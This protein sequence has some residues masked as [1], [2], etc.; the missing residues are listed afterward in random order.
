MHA[1]KFHFTSIGSGETFADF[2]G[3]GF[4][5]AIG[6]E[7]A[8]A[9]AGANFEVEAIDGDHVLISLAKAVTRRA[10]LEATADMDPVSRR[11]Q[12]R[13]SA[14]CGRQWVRLSK[15]D[16]QR[17]DHF[18]PDLGHLDILVEAAY[19]HLE[20]LPKNRQIASS[21]CKALWTF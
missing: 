13:S 21:C 3:G 7:K 11:E 2:D 12:I 4:A 6:T 19:L 16:A 18:L 5:C 8:E 14:D 9:F 15:T 20:C 1:E 17:R 10:G